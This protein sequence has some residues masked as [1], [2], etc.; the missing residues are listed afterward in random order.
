MGTQECEDDKE[1]KQVFN[2]DL[3][4]WW[5][6]LEGRELGEFM[7]HIKPIVDAQKAFILLGKTN[8]ER[9]VEREMEFYWLR[10]GGY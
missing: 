7:K 9:L 4:S 6:G 10:K 2:V 5:T 3:V 1:Y 8:P